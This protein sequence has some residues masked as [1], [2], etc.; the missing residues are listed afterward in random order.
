MA[1]PQFGVGAQLA[2]Q[3]AGTVQTID[4]IAGKSA[5]ESQ[6]R[7]LSAIQQVSGFTHD[8][9]LEQQKAKNAQA[10]CCSNSRPGTR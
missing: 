4:E 9:A 1:E 6:G 8:L 10:C 5:Q 2:G 7:E 3:A